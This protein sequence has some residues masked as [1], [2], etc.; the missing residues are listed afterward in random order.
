G[1]PGVLQAGHG[2]DWIKLYADY[3]AG[4]GGAV[5][6]GTVAYDAVNFTATFTPASILSP[7]TTYTDSNTT[8][9]FPPEI[10]ACTPVTGSA[11]GET[12]NASS[13]NPW[14]GWSPSNS[15]N[16]ESQTYNYY[17]NSISTTSNVLESSSN[18]NCALVIQDLGA[19][20]PVNSKNQAL[21]PD[22]YTAV[23]NAAGQILALDPV[24][25]GQSYRELL[26]GVTQAGSAGRRGSGGSITIIAGT[27]TGAGQ[28]GIPVGQDEIQDNYSI[29]YVPTGT[30]YATIS[31]GPYQ[32]DYAVTEPPATAGGGVQDHNLPQ[33]TSYQCYNPAANG[34]AAQS[35]AQTN[36][37]TNPATPVD[38]VENPQFG[39]ILCQTNPP[40]TYGLYWNDMGSAQ[41]DDLGYWNAVEAFTCSTP[42][43]TN[44]GGGPSTL[45]G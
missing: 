37:D 13:N 6:D 25:D 21:L 3:R 43:Q 34:F 32:G 39:A 12:P 23:E 1:S 44:T 18:N 26:P 4:P 41:S 35:F 17:N 27:G 7:D 9:V 16:C 45:S 19:N 28:N 29:G 10:S 20:V 24:Y 14:W 31:S 33:Q 8:D 15:G 40:H 22:Y 2:A 38:G 11:N 30:S 42:A 5:V 36:N